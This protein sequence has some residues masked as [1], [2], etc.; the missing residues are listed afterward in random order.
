MPRCSRWKLLW[1]IELN[2]KK[3]FKSRKK[4]CIRGN[5]SV[6][7]ADCSG[8]GQ[9]LEIREMTAGPATPPFFS[10]RVLEK[11]K[12]GPVDPQPERH[13]RNQADIG[14]VLHWHR[15]WGLRVCLPPVGCKCPG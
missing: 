14:H 2:D 10:L 1:V 15:V 13:A 9:K 7:S 3:S 5:Y 11:I 4:T 12:G 8:L 6:A